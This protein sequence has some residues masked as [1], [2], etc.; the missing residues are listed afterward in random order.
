MS[1]ELAVRTRAS[2]QQRMS[3]TWHAN[4]AS[5]GIRWLEKNLDKLGLDAAGDSGGSGAGAGGNTLLPDKETQATFRSKLLRAVLDQNFVPSSNAEAMAELRFR[6]NAGRRAR[7][8]REHRRLK[9]EVDQRHAKAETDAQRAADEHLESILT[10]GRERRLAA[11]T[12]WESR[13]VREQQAMQDTKRLEEMKSAEQGAF[14]RV[15]NEFSTCAREQHA[16]TKPKREAVAEALQTKL[17]LHHDNKR[18]RAQLLC[19]GI[20]LKIVD[21]AVVASE[22]RADRGGR[23]LPPSLWMRLKLRFCSPAPF[24]EEKVEPESAVE[25]RN[26]ALEANALLQRRNLDRCR[27]RWR[28]HGLVRAAFEQEVTPLDAALSVARN[29]VEAAGTGPRESPATYNGNRV[30]D[31]SDNT[32]IW[33][34]SVRLVLLGDTASLHSELG[35]WTGLYCCDLDTAL[36]C[37]MDLGAEM[38]AADTKNAGGKKKRKSSVVTEGPE[39]AKERA[40][41]Q[42]QT[43]AANKSYDL[44]AREEDVAT[45]KEAAASYYANRTNPKKSAAPVSLATLT[46]ILV[47]HL[48]C[49]SPPGRRGWILIGYPRSPLEAKMFENALTG[50]MDDDVATELGVGGKGSASDAKKKKIS[51]S[52]KTIAPPPPPKS[53]LDVVLH[54]STARSKRLSQGRGARGQAKK[55]GETDGVNGVLD[56]MD[57]ENDQ[58]NTK[59]IEERY[60]TDVGAMEAAEN[61]STKRPVGTETT[62]HKEE[63]TLPAERRALVEWWSTFE[64]GQLACEVPHEANKERLLET[65]FLLVILAQKRKVKYRESPVS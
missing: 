46:D 29:L 1:Y 57:A 24:F 53:G 12:H 9:T 38:A 18:Q 36:E 58:K 54:I 40:G 62:E 31:N 48:A 60:R 52:H 37:A 5:G 3:R 59:N 2:A 61:F 28:P 34:L 11:A 14:K 35:R 20:A 44:Q 56:D 16:A 39:I 41:T 45:F 4:D 7:R 19:M 26:P 33:D 55:D 23:P 63:H 64:G 8:E 50:Y 15:F 49:R 6:G 17:Q 21:L 65:L 10:V 47:K 25:G 51:V 32:E 27:G 13:R 42:N 30:A 22:T 43:V